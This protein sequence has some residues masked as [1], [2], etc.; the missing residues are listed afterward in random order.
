MSDGPRVLYTSAGAS[1][2]SGAFHML[3]E[4]AAGIRPYG[5]TP[6]LLLPEDVGP[7]ALRATGW[8]A[9]D[10]TTMPL[11]QPEWSRSPGQLGRYAFR[12]AHSTRQTARLLRARP[13]ALIHANEITDLYTGLAARRAG[14]PC[15]WHVRAELSP[16]P[17]YRRL[18]ATL[19]TRLAT[20]IV[21]V[22]QSVRREMFEAQ[23]LPTDKISVLYDPGPDP[24]RF[25]TGV[26]GRAVRREFDLGP[27]DPLVVLVGKLTERKGH[28]LLV[29]AAPALLERHPRA[30]CLIVGGGL[31][32]AHHQRYA[33]ALRA[34]IA[35]LGLGE[36]VRLSGYRAD[37]PAVMAAADVVVHTSLYPDPFPGV[38]LQGM[39]LGKPVVAP[40]LG[41]PLEQLTHLETGYL[42]APR[43]AEALAQALLTLLADAPLRARLGVAAA[44]AVQARF[45]RARFFAALARLYAELNIGDREQGTGNRGG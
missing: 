27:D 42:I 36:R 12:L 37:I 28:R 43:S 31:A 17:R 33:A 40:A 11:P 18:A 5:Y 6:A 23:G 25:H 22:S 16:W 32:G 19:A 29:E 44:A 10:V 21:V 24:A 4:M 15:V 35:A 34:R 30:T 13:F 2:Q 41:G 45:G 38:V 8:S 20:R 7:D 9:D 26:D 1:A 3:V 39:A 14:V